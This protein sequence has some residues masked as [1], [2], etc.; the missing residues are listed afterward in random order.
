MPRATSP[1]EPSEG[2]AAVGAEWEPQSAGRSE[3]RSERRSAAARR[4]RR[5]RGTSACAGDEQR[6]EDQPRQRAI[7]SGTSGL[8]QPRRGLDGF[9]PRG[10]GLVRVVDDQEAVDHGDRIDLQRLVRGWVQGFA[11]LEIEP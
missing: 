6:G 1:L 8:H 3:R 5:G 9:G 4:R 7:G 10:S 2:G 11:G